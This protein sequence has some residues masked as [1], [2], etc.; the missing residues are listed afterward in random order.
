MIAAVALCVSVLGVLLVVLR[1]FSERVICY[2]HNAFLVRNSAELM[3][4]VDELV[5]G[6]EESSQVPRDAARGYRNRLGR[7]RSELEQLSYLR[8]ALF[9]PFVRERRLTKLHDNLSS[10]LD[11]E[12]RVVQPPAQDDIG[13]R[14]NDSFRSRSASLAEVRAVGGQ[15]PAIQESSV[16]FPASRIQYCGWEMPSL[17][18]VAIE[19]WK[20]TLA[21]PPRFATEADIARKAFSDVDRDKLGYFSFRKFL[22]SLAVLGLNVN[23]HGALA[24]FSYLDVDKNGRISVEDKFGYIPNL[25]LNLPQSRAF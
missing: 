16:F 24:K 6:D 22:E 21:R 7:L 4:C 12:D 8:I 18:S 15:R 13:I 14:E 10:L 19:R 2:E 17:D 11:Q 25:T 5:N 1:S 20:K 3:A 23:Y 9:S